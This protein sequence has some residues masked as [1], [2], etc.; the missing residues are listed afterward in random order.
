MGTEHSIGSS[1]LSGSRR[2]MVFWRSFR[3]RLA[4]VLLRF[5]DERA[6]MRAVL[7]RPIVMSGRG[8]LI[9]E[10]SLSFVLEGL[11]EMYVGP[12]C[13]CWWRFR[14]RAEASSI[15]CCW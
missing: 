12:A 9:G 6:E 4:S 5:C 10:L 3:N 7:S 15:S 8:V 2:I 13:C 11:G 1:G 14:G